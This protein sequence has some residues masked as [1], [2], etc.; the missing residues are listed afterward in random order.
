MK[1]LLKMN[2]DKERGQGHVTSKDGNLA[3]PCIM[4]LFPDNDTFVKR[5]WR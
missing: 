2:W 5:S 1:Y 4:T 3:E